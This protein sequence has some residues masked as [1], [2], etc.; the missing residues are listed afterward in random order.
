MFTF[1]Y[2][3]K[4]RKEHIAAFYSKNLFNRLFELLM[5]IPHWTSSL[6][7]F[8]TP[9]FQ[10]LRLVAPGFSQNLQGKRILSGLFGLF[11][12]YISFIVKEVGLFSPKMCPKNTLLSHHRP[13]WVIRLLLGFKGWA[14]IFFKRLIPK[15]SISFSH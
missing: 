1:R 4:C 11:L 13:F 9:L 10:K 2:L 15:L 14:V 3:E 7:N 5:Y 12:P 6:E 8:F